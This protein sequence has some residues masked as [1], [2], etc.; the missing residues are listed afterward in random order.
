[1]ALNTH[2]LDI[3]LSSAQYAYVNDNADV[4]PSGDIT[5]EIWMKM[6]QLPSVPGTVFT[7]VSHADYTGNQ[8]SYTWSVGADNKLDLTVT[9]DGSFTE[10]HTMQ[11][12]SD[13]AVDSGAG[14]WIHAAVSFDISG[15]T[16]VMYKN[17]SPF[18]NSAIGV[19]TPSMGATLHNS[20]AKFALGCKFASGSAERFF[21]GKLDE[22]RLHDTVRSAAWIDANKDDHIEPD[23]NVVGYWKLNN[24]YTDSAKSSDLT[25]V[26]SPVFDDADVPFVGSVAAVA[27]GNP[28]IF[29]GGVVIA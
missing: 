3:E 29:S 26:G 19:G 7:M 22:A 21:D 13:A 12:T 16:C 15:E 20:T 14:N 5:I 10:G 24:D 6:E 25:A 28:M 27:G 8:G 18:A 2:S 17:G 23:A 4:S 11:F 1:M 9:D